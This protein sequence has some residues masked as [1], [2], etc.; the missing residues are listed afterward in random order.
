MTWII[1][2]VHG[3]IKT[4]EA[5]LNKLPS[6]D[7][8]IFVGDLVD[9]GENS[10]DVVQLIIDRGYD[11]VKGNHEDAMC[12]ETHSLLEDKSLVQKSFWVN[13][14]GGLETLK[15]YNNSSK[16]EVISHVN[17]LNNLPYYIEYKDIKN[18]EGRYLVVSHSSIGNY[19]HMRNFPKGSY[20]YNDFNRKIVG[21]RVS[22]PID[23]PEI[24]NVFGHTPNKEAIV[25]QHFANVDT[26]AC[27]EE[28]GN[29]TAIEYPTLRIISQVNID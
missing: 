18:E 27:Y 12:E 13:K 9:R 22:N 15:S 19:W 29:L 7:K 21:N 11:C 1:G 25:K 24:F 28:L 16:E 5:L 23:I 20:E 26:G 2:D 14:C 6:K 4:L 17:W 10:K 8:V 3:C